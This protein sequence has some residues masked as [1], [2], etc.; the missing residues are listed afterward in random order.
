MKNST[1]N[2]LYDSMVKKHLVYTCGE[3]LNNYF[4]LIAAI[5]SL[6]SIPSSWKFN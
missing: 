3:L 4:I 5:K 1:V 2:D 6:W